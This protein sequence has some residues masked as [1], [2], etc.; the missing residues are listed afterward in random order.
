MAD[1][2]VSRRL[3]SR[4][5]ACSTFRVGSKESV[6]ICEN[7]YT[8]AVVTTQFFVLCSGYL[9]VYQTCLLSYPGARQVA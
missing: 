9:C 2:S 3:R 1:G 8:L 4:L 5:L 6:I 7:M